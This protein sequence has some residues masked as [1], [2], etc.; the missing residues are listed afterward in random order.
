MEAVIENH[1]PIL[2]VVFEMEIGGARRERFSESG[3][4]EIVGCDEADG[5][6]VDETAD[7]SLGADSSIVRIRPMQN[8]IQQE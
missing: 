1:A 5:A 4:S 8:F 6:T 3:E 2:E 7:D